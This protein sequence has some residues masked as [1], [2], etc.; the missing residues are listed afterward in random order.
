MEFK[1]IIKPIEIPQMIFDTLEATI[2]TLRTQNL[3]SGEVSF[4]LSGAQITCTII[5]N[6]HSI[7]LKEAG[8]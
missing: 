2:T 4:E 7:A 1:K 6:E 8:E 3:K 5:L